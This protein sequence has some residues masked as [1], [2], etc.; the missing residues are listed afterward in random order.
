MGCLLTLLG[1]DGRGLGDE[2]VRKALDGSEIRSSGDGC[3]IRV[4][5][6]MTSCKVT[7]RPTA[8]SEVEDRK[9]RDRPIPVPR[10]SVARHGSGATGLA[11]DCTHRATF[12]ALIGVDSYG[13]LPMTQG[14]RPRTAWWASC[15]RRGR[16]CV[17]II[18]STLLSACAGAGGGATAEAVRIRKAHPGSRVDATHAIRSGASTSEPSTSVGPAIS[19]W[20][21]AQRAFD[22]AA[23]TADAGAPELAAT[24]VAPQLPWTQALLERMR[25]DGEEA[26][27]TV[28]FVQPRIDM[29]AT[30]VSVAR[31]CGHDNEIVFSVATGRAGARATCRA[32]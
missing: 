24:M 5:R 14:T 22:D 30:D 9:V 29:Q 28:S 20:V 21:A 1:G 23:R 12:I 27:G 13:P 25:A 8:R 26:R 19:A 31:A 32:H 3:P 10:R 18:C 4:S 6:S 7:A 17:I 16:L 11:T 15:S 2:S